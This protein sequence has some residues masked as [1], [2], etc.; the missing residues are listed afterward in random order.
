[1]SFRVRDHRQDSKEGEKDGGSKRRKKKEIGLTAKGLALN[2]ALCAARHDGGDDSDAENYNA[3]EVI[4]ECRT[5][6]KTE[7]TKLLSNHA[8]KFACFK[9]LAELVSVMGESN[10]EIKAHNAVALLEEKRGLVDELTTSVTVKSEK[11]RVWQIAM[12]VIDFCQYIFGGIW[13]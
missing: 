9:S 6:V 2:T 4:T 3:A 8:V 13:S 10:V 7:A 1:M 5:W 11:Q 12:I